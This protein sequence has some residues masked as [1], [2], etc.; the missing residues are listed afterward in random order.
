MGSSLCQPSPNIDIFTN[1]ERTKMNED[2]NINA[3]NLQI[4]RENKPEND[5]KDKQFF[6]E[7]LEYN[8]SSVVNHF[9]DA[10]KIIYQFWKDY[11]L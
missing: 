8:L 2:I 3:D 1:V 10:N 6:N 11:Y 4:D 5:P 7:K 9:C